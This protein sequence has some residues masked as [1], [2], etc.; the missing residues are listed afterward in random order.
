MRSPQAPKLRRTSHAQTFR[1]TTC[2]QR[3]ER[4]RD[5]GKSEGGT[6]IAAALSTEPEVV[7]PGHVEDGPELL[8]EHGH[9]AGEVVPR[10]GD[11]AGD[12]ERVDHPVLPS[13]RAHLGGEPAH[14]LHV[15]RVVGVE[16]GDDED[17]RGR[18]GGRRRL[19]R[20]RRGRCRGRRAAPDGAARRAERPAAPPPGAAVVVVRRRVERVVVRGAGGYGQMRRHVGR[21]REEVA[22]CRSLK[23]LFPFPPPFVLG[24]G[25]SEISTGSGG[26]AG[27]SSRLYTRIAAARCAGEGELVGAATW[28][29]APERD[30]IF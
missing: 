3:T 16:V 20:G 26:P 10:L 8:P 24:R 2:L 19:P 27:C 30:G 1:Q 6:H 28:Q 29:P 13:A 5:G 25:S 11:V 14:P 18:R 22:A 9:G 15:L 21:S 7:I 17:P 4:G 12:D 23:N